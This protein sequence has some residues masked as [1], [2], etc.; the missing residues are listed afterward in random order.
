MKW[1]VYS[2][3]VL[4][5]LAVLRAERMETFYLLFDWVQTLIALCLEEQ[6]IAGAL[7]RRHAPYRPLQVTP[8]LW[9]MS[10][11]DH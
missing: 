9:P 10:V 5:N 4:C 2:H 1:G 11:V 3:L 8:S 6:E 7:R